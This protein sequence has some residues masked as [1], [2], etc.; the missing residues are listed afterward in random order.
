MDELGGE[1]I[2]II[3]LSENSA[4]MISRALSPANVLKVSVNEEEKQAIV[5]VF[6]SERAKAIWKNGININLA[7]QLL[8]YNISVQIVED[9]E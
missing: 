1:K 9:E 3:S 4:E 2:D 5:T 7:S 6:A 8:W